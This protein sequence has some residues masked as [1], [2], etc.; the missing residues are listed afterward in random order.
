MR[1]PRAIRAR[2]SRFAATGAPSTRPSCACSTRAGRPGW[3]TSRWEL[4]PR[5]GARADAVPIQPAAHLAFLSRP[6]LRDALAWTSLCAALAWAAWIGWIAWRGTRL[7]DGTRWYGDRDEARATVWAEPEELALPLPTGRTLVDAA[8]S[9]DGAW[10]ALALADERGSTDLYLAP[11]DPASGLVRDTPRALDALNSPGRDE[12]PAWAEGELWFASDRDGGAGGLDLWRARKG[13]RQWED[14]APLTALNGPHEDT[15]P[16]PARAG[17]E[18]VFASNRPRDGEQA[19]DYELWFAR[20]LDGAPAHLSELGS[21]GAE[22][23]P[24]WGAD[25]RTLWFRSDRGGDDELYRARHAA[26]AWSSP[27]HLAA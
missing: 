27:E 10:L 16:A 17:G 14:L 23:E 1:P 24:A 19:G 12:A 18:C 5:L 11:L 6:R 22:R 26:G 7:T 8:P 21:D 20:A 9:L 25:A 13:R 2:P 3:P 4:P 15:D